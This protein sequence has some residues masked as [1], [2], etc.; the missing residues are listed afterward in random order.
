MKGKNNLKL[1]VTSQP[2]KVSS[3][4]HKRLFEVHK[5]ANSL[6][7]LRYSK[8]RLDNSFSSVFCVAKALFET[9]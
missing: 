3:P 8:I 5:A 2:Q 6:N 1:G 9:K 4:N 7:N